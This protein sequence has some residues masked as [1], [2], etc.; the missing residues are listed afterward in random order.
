MS[1]YE[2][3]Y[4]EEEDPD[5]YMYET[6]EGDSGSMAVAT[7]TTQAS[8][9]QPPS[10]GPRSGR[11]RRRLA[12]EGGFLVLQE[13]DLIAEREEAVKAVCELLGLEPHEAQYVLMEFS[14][15]NEKVVE[16]F[17]NKGD[18]ELLKSAGVI[19]KPTA[20]TTSTKNNKN[21]E[22]QSMFTCGVCFDELA[23][24]EGAAL[25]CGHRYCLE[26]WGHHVDTQV[27]DGSCRIRCM[28]EGCFAMCTPA[29]VQRA[30]SSTSVDRF[31]KALTESYVADN[32][33]VAYCPSVPPCGR[34]IKVEAHASPRV[35]VECE[36]ENIFCFACKQPSHTPA[37]CDW[38]V[39]W[40]R[41]SRDESETA[42][43]L[44]A[45][46]KPCPKCGRNIFKADGCNHV[47]CVCG[48]C[49]CWLCGAATGSAHTWNSIQDHTC[50][51]FRAKAETDAAKARVEL[52]R[53]MHYFNRYMA[54]MD[55]LNKAGEGAE[56]RVQETI[57]EIES[58]TVVGARPQWHPGVSHIALSGQPTST[59]TP[60]L[61]AGGTPQ[62]GEK[63]AADAAVLADWLWIGYRQLVRMRSIVAWSYAVAFYAFYE[64]NGEAL[65]TLQASRG[66]SNFH[67][68]TLFEDLQASLEKTVEQLSKV[69]ET[70][71]H[72]MPPDAKT[73]V[74]ELTSLSHSQCQNMFEMVTELLE[75]CLGLPIAPYRPIRRIVVALGASAKGKPSESPSSVLFGGTVSPV[76]AAGSV[77]STASNIVAALSLS[78]KGEGNASAI[79]DDGEVAVVQGGSA[80]AGAGAALPA[81]KRR[82][83]GRRR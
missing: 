22:E 50:G 31:S 48:Q 69:V 62:Q 79:A 4:E 32:P 44:T 46:C 16:W 78:P 75:D 55:S 13:D 38:A 14:W 11:A 61:A 34:V 42:T 29:L 70:P 47:R 64:T 33:R 72:D 27:R 39:K 68:Q 17:L 52:V 1:D 35:E 25:G 71:L 36:C 21:K 15:D 19:R 5:E 8:G 56:R 12:G 45:H 59:A 74:L 81:P 76:P 7:P 58:G 9:S 23:Q 51:A 6:D 65:R 18:E 3:E 10:L 80:A 63:H 24:R 41:K 77:S 66:L 30:A 40:K 53:Y 20:S 82:K 43:F 54:H 67:L 2:Y 60:S 26:C 83:K 73:K 28:A 57:A 49:M 37:P